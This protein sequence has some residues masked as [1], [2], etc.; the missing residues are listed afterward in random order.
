MEVRQD[1]KEATLEAIIIRADGTRIN[2]GVISYYHSNPLKRWFWNIKH[3]LR[4]KLNG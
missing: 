3:F 2:L 1:I 4:G